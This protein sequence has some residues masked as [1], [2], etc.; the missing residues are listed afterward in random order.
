M[1]N[2]LIEY[3]SKKYEGYDAEVDGIFKKKEEDKRMVD[4]LNRINHYSICGG[5]CND[6]TCLGTEK[7]ITHIKTCKK[8]ICDICGKLRDIFIQHSMGC[9]R[10]HCS[11]PYCN[12][13]SCRYITNRMF[14]KDI[15]PA[16]IFPDLDKLTTKS[17]QNN[18]KCL[19][20]NENKCYQTGCKTEV[21]RRVREF[22]DHSNFCTDEYCYISSRVKNFRNYAQKCSQIKSKIEYNTADT[23]TDIKKN[24]KTD[25][26]PE[27][28][29]KTNLDSETVH[30]TDSKKDVEKDEEKFEYKVIYK[31][32]YKIRYRIETKNENLFQSKIEV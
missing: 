13:N 21:C 7:Y 25:V 28:V 24:F 11:I 10:V 8:E 16:Y 22:I 14:F 1:I 29:L 6:K 2:C 4:F 31:S 20:H 32:K 30:K 5:V 3:S 26:D 12:N 18:I 27:T 9:I 23:K 15:M 17:L 19:S